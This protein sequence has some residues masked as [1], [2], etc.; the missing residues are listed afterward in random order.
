M[1]DLSRREWFKRIGVAATAISLA[2]CQRHVARNVDFVSERLI[3]AYSPLGEI[4]CIGCENCM[5]C[6]YGIDIPSNLLFIDEA[7]RKDYLP[8]S[9]SEADF[10][11]KGAEFLKKFEDKIPDSSQSQKC[12][13]CGKCLGVCPM[14]IE[15]PDRLS[16]I[17]ALTDLLRNLRC[18][19]S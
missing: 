12:I 2:S 15:I 14:D 18:Q 9:P 19:E 16:D 10:E 1:A 3:K 11:A 5:P 17:T 6:P 4:G 8:G 7:M 13:G